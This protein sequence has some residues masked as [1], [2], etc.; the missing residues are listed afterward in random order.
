[1][2]VN[3]DQIL[4]AH[5]ST[6]PLAKAEW[7]RDHKLRQDPRI[8]KLG[9]L[10]RMTSLDELPQLWNVLV[11]EMSLVGPRPIVAAEVARYQHHFADYCRCRPGIT[12]LWQISGRNDVS[13]D[14]R[15]ALDVQYA[16][17]RSTWLNL[18]IML[19]TIPAVLMRKGCY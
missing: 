13:Y 8:T 12:G 11:G 1:M 4:L 9:R 18:S 5:L 6:S 7:E 3:A 10:L 15:V 19:N 2:A 16:Q 14:Q 17:T